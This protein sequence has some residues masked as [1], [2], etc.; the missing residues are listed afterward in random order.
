M[1]N[2]IE[3]CGNCITYKYDNP[4]SEGGCLKTKGK[5]LSPLAPV[6]NDYTPKKE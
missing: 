6:C 1:K 3:I 4:A 2:L 5:T